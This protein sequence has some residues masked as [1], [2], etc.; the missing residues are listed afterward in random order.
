MYRK[1]GEFE[2]SKFSRKGEVQNF[3]MQREGLVK[4]KGKGC[5]KKGRDI[6][7]TLINFF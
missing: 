2:S 6:A 5:S 7:K 4:L 3:S 1:V